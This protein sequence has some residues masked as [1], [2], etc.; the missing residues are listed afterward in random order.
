MEGEKL[1]QVGYLYPN[2]SS[3]KGASRDT[4]SAILTVHQGGEW[5][6]V[7]W[8]IQKDETIRI[9]ENGKYCLHQHRNSHKHY[10][11]INLVMGER[12]LRIGYGPCS[13][14]NKY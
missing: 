6:V 13:E 4:D 2:P 11:S 1:D 10:L 8:N 3:Q 7:S 12:I 9:G 5:H 14:H